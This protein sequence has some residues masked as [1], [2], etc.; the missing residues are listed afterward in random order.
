MKFAHNLHMEFGWIFFT[1]LNSG[2][3]AIA[4]LRLFHMNLAL[5]RKFTCISSIT[6]GAGQVHSLMGK[7]LLFSVLPDWVVSHTIGLFSFWRL[8]VK[9]WSKTGIRR[10]SVDLCPQKSIQFGSSSSRQVFGH[11]CGWK[12]LDKVC[13]DSCSARSWCLRNVVVGPWSFS[14]S[15]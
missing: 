12:W 2:L 11:F 3:L 6:V 14:W 7:Q 1:S 9:K 8:W 4:T 13:E 15:L 10:F 5:L